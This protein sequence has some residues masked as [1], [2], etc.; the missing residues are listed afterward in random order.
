MK[1]RLLITVCTPAFVLVMMVSC[2][3]APD[4]PLVAELGGKN[5]QLF[6]DP[7]GDCMGMYEFQYDIVKIQVFIDRYNTNLIVHITFD[8]PVNPPSTDMDTDELVGYMEIDAD[9][10]PSTGSMAVIDGLAPGFLP[11]SNMGV[12][13]SVYF[14]DYNS[15]SQ[16]VP[17]YNENFINFSGYA[18]IYYNDTSCT[19]QIPLRT[20]GFDDGNINFGFILGTWSEPTDVAYTYTY[21]AFP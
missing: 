5:G 16:T 19:L 17:I 10:D 18:F 8:N 1:R 11:P 15:I 3:V 4:I 7:F 9:Q 20:L 13:Y 21:N 12:D 6:Q 14:W 2:S